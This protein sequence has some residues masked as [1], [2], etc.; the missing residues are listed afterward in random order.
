ML[1]FKPVKNRITQAYYL[2]SVITEVLVLKLNII[3]NLIIRNLRQ[4]A[5]KHE[6]FERFD[7]LRNLTSSVTSKYGEKLFIIA[8]Q[9]MNGKL[10]RKPELPRNTFQ[11]LLFTRT[12][13]TN[14]IEFF[15]KENE[16]WF[17]VRYFT[18]LFWVSTQQNT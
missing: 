10:T 3:K 13:A 15:Q 14:Y 1:W 12:T 5:E 16:Q 6:V 8:I 2:S 17:Y 7:E 11:K 18:G 9:I 4:E